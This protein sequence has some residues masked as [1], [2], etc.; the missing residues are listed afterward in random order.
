MLSTPGW[1]GRSHTTIFDDTVRALQDD[2]VRRRAV[3]SCYSLRRPLQEDTVVSSSSTPGPTPI[4]CPPGV[5]EDT[6]SES[7]HFA[8]GVHQDNLP[9][10]GTNIVLPSR[11]RHQQPNG[12]STRHENHITSHPPL[13]MRSSQTKLN[14]FEEEDSSSIRS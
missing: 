5:Q 4:E 8:I 10:Q 9:R 3:L 13:L 2:T 12:S 11:I 6:Q 7:D 14:L 1:H